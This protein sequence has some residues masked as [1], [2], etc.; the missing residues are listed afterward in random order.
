VK[1]QSDTTNPVGFQSIAPS[2]PEEQV[3]EPQ[4]EIAN[5]GAQQE[6][7]DTLPA[8]EP[9]ATVEEQKEASSLL[10]EAY[11]VKCKTKTEVRDAHEVTTKNGRIAIRGIC[12]VCGTNLFR[13]GRIVSG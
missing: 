7:D 5:T 6:I 4:P 10:I 2:T 11:C 13:I 3:Q 8:Q 1:A 9:E 12:A